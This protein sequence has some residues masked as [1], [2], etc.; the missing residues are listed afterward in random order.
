MTIGTIAINKI[1]GQKQNC[2][3]DPVFC[4]AHLHRAVTLFASLQ[5]DAGVSWLDDGICG[6]LLSLGIYGIIKVS[7]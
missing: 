7:S 5:R 4:V 6:P 2:A 1:L 3:I